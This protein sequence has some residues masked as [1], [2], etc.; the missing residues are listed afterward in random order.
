LRLKKEKYM[1]LEGRQG[2]VGFV[3][4]TIPE[5]ARAV[6]LRPFALGEQTGHSHR[7]SVL[8]APKCQMFEIDGRT[9]IRVS[10][11]GGIS[12]QHEDHD[13]KALKSILPAGWE[14]E[15]VIAREYD[16]ETDFRRVMD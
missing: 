9:F 14:G 1:K 12:I 11:E 7:V 4:C 15:V 10:E 5:G 8:D 6:K 2:D 16:E 3:R 13:P